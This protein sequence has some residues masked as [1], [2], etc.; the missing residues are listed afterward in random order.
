MI[1]ITIILLIPGLGLVGAQ[2]LVNATAAFPQLSLFTQLLNIDP[3]AAAAFLT[4][5]TLNATQQTVLVPSNEAFERYR[6]RSGTNFSALS[7]S[8]LTNTLNYHTLQGALS[9]SDLQRPG[10]L[11]SDT[12]LTVQP[13]ANRELSSSGERQAQV[14]Y[15]SA[16]NT[17]AGARIRARQ[18]GPLGS[19]AA[20][21]GEGREISLDN[22]RGNWSGGY[23]YIV[24]GY[25]QKPP[26]RRVEDEEHNPGF[27]PKLAMRD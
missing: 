18:A 26:T 22:T 11:V 4:N 23:F 27:P 24:D 25:V 9:S 16:T 21:S 10:G 5:F 13:Y 14:V 3:N 7:S 19:I 2:S 15:L 20:K 17:T 12:A 8:D 6:S 1:L